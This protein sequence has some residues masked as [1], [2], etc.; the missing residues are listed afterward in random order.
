[1]LERLIEFM[2]EEGWDL[3]PSQIADVLW[4]W[5]QV[6]LDTLGDL[7]ENIVPVEGW[8]PRI[9]RKLVD[10]FKSLESK[11]AKEE[12]SSVS[13]PAASSPSLQLPSSEHYPLTTSAQDQSSVEEFPIKVPDTGILGNTLEL[14]RT[15]KPLKQKINSRIAQELDILETVRQSA[16]LSLPG[17]PVYFP[18]LSPKKVRWL[19]AVILIEKSESMLLWQPLLAEVQDFLENLGAFRDIKSYQISWDEIQDKLH[20]HPLQFPNQKIAPQCLIDASGRRL[21]LIISDCISSAWY[22][23]KYTQTLRQWGTKGFITL[24]NPFPESL[25]ERTALGYGVKIRLGNQNQGLVSQQWQAI[26]FSSWEEHKINQQ[27][28]VKLPILSLERESMG[29]WVNVI[30]GKGKSLCAGAWLTTN[31]LAE[32]NN[33]E[34]AAE[35]LSPWQQINQFYATSSQ[36]AWQLIQLLSAI[37]VTLSTIRLV[38]QTLIPDSKQVNVAE[39]VMSDLLTPEAPLKDYQ[40][41]QQIQFQF[42]PGIRE[43]FQE[44]LGGQDFVLTVISKLTEKLAERFGY[45]IREFEAIILTNPLKL[46]SHEDFNLLQVF[47]T[48]TV[49]TL[50]QYGGKYADYAQQLEQ[51]YSRL[52]IYPNKE[53]IF[54]VTV[55]TLTVVPTTS[56]PNTSDTLQ[57]FEDETV[58]VN[59]RGKIIRREPLKAYYYDESLSANHQQPPASAECEPIRMIA[60]PE[61]EFWMGSS[62][63][64]KERYNDESP[65]HK[66]KVPSFFM[67]QTSITEA[68]WRFVANLPQQQRK[69]NPNPSSDGDNHPVSYV[70]WYDAIEFC[71]RLSSYSR[72]DYRLPS[73]AEWEYACRAIQNENSTINNVSYP[74]FHFGETLTTELANYGGSTYQQEPEGEYR[75]ETTPVR[76][77][78]P[79]A[80]GLYDMHGNVWEW[81]LDPW[82]DNYKGAPTDGS[83]WDEQNENDNRYHYISKNI[84]LF[85]EDSRTHVLRGG[86]CGSLPR[87]CRSAYRIYFS[88]PGVVGNDIGFRVVCALARTF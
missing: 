81:C 43:A 37:P 26:P 8:I 74:S 79:N 40:H 1:M 22:R 30:T 36:F 35:N 16:E 14:G 9:W 7:R 57:L 5:Q 12:N 62:K 63:K 71:A 68:Q 46:T 50:R 32:V 44:R 21:I 60:I 70:S 88:Y 52:S 48:I 77:F 34:E 51:S 65:Q 84:D 39:V 78:K 24:L 53:T 64:K 80:F 42:K 69:L 85:L 72:R 33:Q 20:I 59:R 61:G 27:T 4:F 67:S 66:V 76:S 83:V 75:G 55:A 23:G 58:F 2:V 47:A 87:N 28:S 41:P 3:T 11:E 73:E 10:I 18:V 29:A 17:F 19:D 31:S 6:E 45:S 38:Q 13:L 86:S 15:A 54:S 82:H 49:S 25:W 56:V